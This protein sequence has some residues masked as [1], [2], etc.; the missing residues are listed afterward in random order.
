MLFI[1]DTH[2]LWKRYLETIKNVPESIQL[3]DMGVGFLASWDKVKNPYLM[4]PI[5]PD[6]HAFIRGN[7]DNPEVCKHTKGCL[8]SYGVHKG[9][10][11]ISGAMSHPS[12]MNRM[13]PNRWWPDEEL[14]QEE[15]WKAVDLYK[16]VR[17]KVVCSHDCPGAVKRMILSHHRMDFSRTDQALNVMLEEHSP[18]HWIFGH[19][20]QRWERTVLGCK[21][22]CLPE[23]AVE[24][25]D[26]TCV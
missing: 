25:I 3:G 20:H 9:V 10:F 11:Y 5:I 18:D 26:I 22:L 24:E 6:G 15:L 1:G 23:L 16:E 21:F 19:H 17:P 12:D 2:G 14:P 8:W 13:M 7:H 4:R